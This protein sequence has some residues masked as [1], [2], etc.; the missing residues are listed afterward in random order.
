MIIKTAYHF[1]DSNQDLRYPQKRGVSRKRMGGRDL[2]VVLPGRG[3]M[4]YL[5]EGRVYL[6]NQG[7]GK[8]YRLTTKLT[9]SKTVVKDFPYTLRVPSTDCFKSTASNKKCIFLKN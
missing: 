9:S 6:G 2:E 3:Q 7:Q 8:V 1:V 4:T 5:G